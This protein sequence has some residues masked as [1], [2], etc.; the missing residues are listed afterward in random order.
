MMQ[1]RT[2]VQYS[3]IVADG[4][5]W[6][7]ARMKYRKFIDEHD[8]FSGV[9]MEV[10]GVL[11]FGN[12][13]GGGL[14]LQFGRDINLLKNRW[15][16]DEPQINYIVK[17]SELNECSKDGKLFRRDLGRTLQFVRGQEFQQVR[18]QYIIDRITSGAPQDGQAAEGESV[19]VGGPIS[20]RSGEDR[21][22]GK[23]FMTKKQTMTPFR[24]KL[25]HFSPST[26]KRLFLMSNTPENIRA[27]H[28]IVM[29]SDTEE[30]VLEKMKNLESSGSQNN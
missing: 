5:I 13:N 21:R 29:E 9:V 27:T 11:Y 30:E 20:E 22:S 10:G 1:T 2:A 28:K 7:T 16:L 14:K 25:T 12:D 3:K 15:N 8:T 17:E 24:E 18:D 4:D 23:R 26:K 6:T 19:Y